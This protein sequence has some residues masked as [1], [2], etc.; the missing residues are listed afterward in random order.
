MAPAPGRRRAGHAGR[1]ARGDRRRVG[2]KLA[3]WQ[4]RSALLGRDLCEAMRE[5]IVSD[6][7]SPDWS[8]RA[9]AK[10]ADLRA[11][12]RDAGAGTA[13]L[14]PDAHGLRLWTFGGGKA[15]NLLARVLEEA[16]GEKVVVDN[17]YLGFRGDAARSD[18][19]I[20]AAL[21]ALRLAARPSHADALRLA[22]G[23]ARG[24]LSKFQPCLPPR[25][26]SELLAESL[27]DAPAARS[28]LAALVAP[29]P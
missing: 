29:A 19:A 20:R 8:R 10:L 4:G 11:E 27:T 18:A 9:Q 2:S 5:L 16:L 21:A 7:V 26:E 22:A 28:V 14:V 13:A 17:L 25:L 24:R 15:N 6:D 12:Y 1:R 3:R 23:C